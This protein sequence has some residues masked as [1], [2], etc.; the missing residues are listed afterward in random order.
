M[1][2]AIDPALLSRLSGETNN[3]KKDWEGFVILLNVA[4]ND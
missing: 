1:G 3:Y 2:Q 4:I